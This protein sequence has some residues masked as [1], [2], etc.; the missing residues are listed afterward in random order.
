M[1]NG[2]MHG[3]P[4]AQ[5][6]PRGISLPLWAHVSLLLLACIGC[7]AAALLWLP[8]G[9]RWLAVLAIL[10]AGAG[11]SY[12]ITHVLRQLSVEADA[13][14]GFDFSDHP[15]SRSRVREADVLGHGLD[16][17]RDTVRRF[18]ALNLE[19]A[20]E[21][22]I[23]TL[24]PLL[25]ADMQLAAAAQGGVLY[26][27]DPADGLLHVHAT[28]GVAADGIT[29]PWPS[30]RPSALPALLQQAIAQRHSASGRLDGAEREVPGLQAL[31][32]G[33]AVVAVPLFD[34]R[35]A[36]TGLMLLFA[37]HLADA[38]QLRFLDA[39][40]ANAGLML[41]TRGLLRD[42]KQ[43][44][45]AVIRMLAGAIDAQSPYTG[46]HCERVPELTRLLVSA[47]CETGEGAFADFDLDADEWEAVHIASWLHDCGKIATPEYVV[48]KATKLETIHNRIHEVRTRFEVLKRDAEIA[49]WRG[50]AEG[51][52]RDVLL[53]RLQAAH[54]QL[55]ADFAFIAGCN[56]GGEFL[57]DAD[58]QRLHA[59]GQRNWMRTLDD[60]IGLSQEELARCDGPPATLP[61]REALLADKP[62][63]RIDH[64]PLD[65]DD[66]RRLAGFRMPRPELRSHRGELHNLGVSRGTLTAEDRYIINEH[67]IHTIVMLEQ[68]PFPPHL[69]SVPELAGAHHEK[70]DGTGYPRRLHREEMSPVARMMAVA[71]VFE[72]LTAA[73]RPYKT[74]KTLSESLAIMARMCRDAHLDPDIFELFLRSGVP[75]TYGERFLDPAQCDRVDTDALLR[76]A[77]LGP[78][79]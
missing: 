22:D 70:M 59:I 41:E 38:G 10:L 14:R 60:R 26:L 13:I 19:L 20:R 78:A 15:V 74:A 76:T 75:Q 40:A 28:R 37:D 45:D 46:G 33:T 51:G 18:L 30:M 12:T 29:P 68:L 49:C 9:W 6:M 64:A 58:R 23:D 11:F 47:A 72:A 53:D 79:A 17:M 32:A 62:E 21:S 36:C 65:A 56:V 3:E 8:V 25:L 73:D 1:I 24:L 4:P 69:R 66:H 52:P 31:P 7:T 71:D 44:L 5:S 57:G 39:L 34:R 2:E 50:I 48:D 61:V 35:D 43:L 67:M 77:G 54:A 27:V 16:L 63:H 42:R 55:D